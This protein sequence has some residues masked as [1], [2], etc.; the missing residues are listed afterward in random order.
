MKKVVISIINFNGKENTLDCLASLERLTT[1]GFVISVIVIDNNSSESFALE[2]KKY[3]KFT[4][5]TV[6][7]QHN[8]GFAGGHNIGIR[9]AKE[10]DADYLIIL[11]NDTKVDRS[12]VKELV[13]AMEANKNAAVASPKIYFAP[14]TEFH[15]G[16]YKEKDIGKVIWYAGGK[17]DWKNVIG[18]HRGVDE[19]DVGQYDNPEKTEFATGCCMILRM[20][21]LLKSGPFD[22]RYFLY[23]EDSDLQERMRA[24]GYSIYYVPKGVLW[25]KNAASGG[26]SGSL[27]QD[28]YISRNRLLFGYLYA[29]IR[30]KFA[31]LR[32]SLSLMASG[33]KWQKRGIVDFYLGKLGKGS[34]KPGE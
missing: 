15:K 2:E 1:D 28:Y 8:L 9:Y 16:T 10:Q 12:L 14:G 29:P 23:Y 4:L 22:S 21:A 27:L 20:S 11:N 3:T 34:F 25:H 7:N 13:V 19:V 32:E 33:R 6:F 17:M 5:H 30:S 24:L 18:S 26:G 31:L